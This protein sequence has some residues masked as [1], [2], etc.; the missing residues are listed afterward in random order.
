MSS[1]V[2]LTII[3]GPPAS[4]KSTLARY[5]SKKYNLPLLQ[6]DTLQEVLFDSLTVADTTKI[7]EASYKILFNQADELAK[8]SIPFI[9]ESNFD[10][11]NHTAYFK[12]LED[13]YKVEIIQV[14]CDAGHSVLVN[15]FEERWQSGKR[16]PKHHDNERFMGLRTA[17]LVERKPM[18]LTG[19][20][21][22]LDTT[23][24]AKVNYQEIE[25]AINSF[26]KRTASND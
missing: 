18:K 8:H 1:S 26:L 16:H 17:T 9:M 7:R 13:I 20:L 3:T 6:L 14:M 10:A 22:T 19:S 24:V 4:G 21:I 12:K 11:K 15:R 23:S 2:L 5:L 25:M